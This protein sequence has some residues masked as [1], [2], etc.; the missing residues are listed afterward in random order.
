M[1]ES[2]VGTDNDSQDSC[3]WYFQA[4][5]EFF[6]SSCLFFFFFGHPSAYGSSQARDKIWNTTA[7]MLGP[8][9]HCAGT[10]IEPLSWCCRDTTHPVGPQQ[11]LDSFTSERDVYL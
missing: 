5:K 4:A 8:L 11:E 3:G 7:A 10:G 6:L 2:F 9:T 1:A